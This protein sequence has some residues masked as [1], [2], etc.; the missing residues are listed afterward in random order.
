MSLEQ[1][2]RILE[3]VQ[4]AS[5][6]IRELTK[7]LKWRTS[8]VVFLSRKMNEERLIEFRTVKQ[9]N[10]G[11]PKKTMVITSL[12]LDFLETYRKL[13]TTPLRARKQDLDHAVKDALFTQRLISR[14]H[15]PFKTFM[16]LNTIVR[17][18]K[19]TSETHQ[20]L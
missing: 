1:K 6:G 2:A 15:S 14:G 20:T 5:C 13:E 10:R 11:R 9:E 8:S 16:E 18:I 19:V 3:A 12:G 7:A 4:L 17:N